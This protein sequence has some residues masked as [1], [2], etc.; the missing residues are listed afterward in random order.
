MNLVFPPEVPRKKNDEQYKYKNNREIG[1]YL[2]RL[3]QPEGEKDMRY[4]QDLPRKKKKKESITEVPY[5]I[6]VVLAIVCPKRQL[7]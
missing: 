6:L 3:F 5:S 4:C 2:I 1:T 7:K